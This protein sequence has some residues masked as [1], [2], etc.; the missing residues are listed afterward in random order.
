MM[1]DLF[2]YYA[3]IPQQWG[4]LS[5]IINP[6]GRGTGAAA[7]DLAMAPV[8]GAIVHGLSSRRL[9]VDVPPEVI[10]SFVNQRP[11][12]RL[13]MVGIDPLDPG[14]EATIEHAIELGLHGV[15]ISP[16]LAGFHPAHTRAMQLYAYCQDHGL[17]LFVASTTPLPTDAELS[18]G[19]P[20]LFDEVALAFPELRIVL[21]GCG[22]PFWPQ[23]V[24]MIAKHPH[25]YADLSFLA[26]RPMTL[27]HL[28]S[29]AIASGAD[30]RL[31]LASGFP[32]STP[33]DIIEALYSIPM[34]LKGTFLPPI[35]RRTVQSIVE[36]D[37]LPLL[38]LPPLDQPDPAPDNEGVALEEFDDELV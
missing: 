33:E 17:P 29:D 38:Q 30:D 20:H 26:Q 28:L 6:R 13:G 36:R 16:T 37:P 31:F 3:T 2:T 12:T 10:A 25:V 8:N 15:T 4:A 19:A 18:L 32:A 21:S 24:A 9:G 5:P 11:T 23:A 22:G 35:P 1:I 7:H 27:Y 14:W 34:M